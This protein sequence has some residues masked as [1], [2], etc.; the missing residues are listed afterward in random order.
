MDITTQPHSDKENFSPASHQKVHYPTLPLLSPLRTKRPTSHSSKASPTK[1]QHLQIDPGNSLG[2]SPIGSPANTSR[3]RAAARV[4]GLA[5]S[6]A[7]AS[8]S[9]RV[10]RIF[11]DS[12]TRRGE[13]DGSINVS[14]DSSSGVSS[15]TSE[16]GVEVQD[17]SRELCRRLDRHDDPSVTPAYPS[18]H[19]GVPR[20]LLPAAPPPSPA[21]TDETSTDSWTGDDEFFPRSPRST[22]RAHRQTLSTER[23]L[24]GTAN[25][26]KAISPVDQLRHGGAARLPPDLLGVS[27]R[28]GSRFRVVER[29]AVEWSPCSDVDIFNKLEAELSND[30]PSDAD[31]EEGESSDE[32]EN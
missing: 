13:G 23:K 20:F 3:H 15:A 27:P 7:R 8:H 26:A 11:H 21:Q 25:R 28:R 19:A 5:G 32:M 17:Y 9:E 30:R 22:I 29:E 14:K 18:A 4:A 1:K 31:D 10:K 16:H 24:R 2:F 12:P 6:P